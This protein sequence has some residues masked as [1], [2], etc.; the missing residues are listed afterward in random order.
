ME[1]VKTKNLKKYFYV[2]G[3]VIKAVDGPPDEYERHPS[4]VD[5]KPYEI[6]YYHNIEGG[7]EFVFVDKSGFSDYILVHSTKRNE[8]RDDN[9]R[10]HI[11]PN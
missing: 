2:W 9:W 5:S 7:V 10:I 6:W 1:K 4:E 8:I 11:A 3:K